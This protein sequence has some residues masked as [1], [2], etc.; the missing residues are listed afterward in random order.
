MRGLRRLVSGWWWA[1]GGRPVRNGVEVV[2]VLQYDPSDR[3]PTA[4]VHVVRMS[5]WEA[6]ELISELAAAAE[7]AWDIKTRPGGSEGV[8]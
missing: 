3:M 6:A 1:A 2:L 4:G 7:L 5:P 8:S